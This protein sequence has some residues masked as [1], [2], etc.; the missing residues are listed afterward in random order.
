MNAM[1]FHSTIPTPG[2]RFTAAALGRVQLRTAL[3][4]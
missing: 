1:R 4:S 3:A 2:S